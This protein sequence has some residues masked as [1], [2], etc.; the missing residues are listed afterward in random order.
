MVSV[1]KPTA[2]ATNRRAIP[3]G[4]G[5][6]PA[7]SA[8]SLSPASSASSEITRF[9]ATGTPLA[10]DAPVPRS[11][12]RSAI[13]WLR[14]RPPLSPVAIR[15]SASR[16]NVACRH[17]ACSIGS[18]TLRYAI[19]SGAGRVVTRRSETAL[20]YRAT[21]AAASSSTARAFAFATRPRSP[22]PSRM[23]GSEH[24][25]RSTTARSAAD[26]HAV[27]RTSSVAR[28]SF[29]RPDRNNSNVCGISCTTARANPRC[30]PPRL[31]DS[32][33]AN[34]ICDPIP[35]S[36]SARGNRR[37][38]RSSRM[39]A[40]TSS[41][42]TACTAHPTDFNDSTASSH[43]IPNPASPHGP[44]HRNRAVNSRNSSRSGATTSPTTSLPRG[45]SKL[46]STLAA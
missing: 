15:L 2:S 35:R 4:T 11:N 6:N 20:R 22:T 46:C 33:R 37:A 3:A 5:P 25:R 30:R 13:T 19:E 9:T 34:A 1:S 10:T 26:R 7:R 42:T 44:T 45:F 29:N 8:A 39:Q 36:H 32:L 28:H 21:T 14:V 16:P 18:S 27:S 38:L 12:N 31:G 41:V 43:S 23:F 17:T 24:N 40:A